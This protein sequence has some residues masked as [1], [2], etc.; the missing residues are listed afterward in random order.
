LVAFF[1]KIRLVCF[2]KLKF[3]ATVMSSLKDL[4]ALGKEFGYEGES[5]RKFIQEEQ[6]RERDERA[7]ARELEREL[8]REKRELEKKAKL[9]IIE[10]EEKKIEM[11][12]QLDRERKELERE[13]RELEREAE[14]RR[15]ELEK[16]AK[17]EIIEAEE[18]KIEMAK[19]LDREKRELEREV[20]EKRVELEKRARLEIIEAE[21]R[22]RQ[23]DHERQLELATA[24]KGE[25]VSA[26]SKL[27]G[28]KLPP[29]DDEKDNM[30]SYL[31]R[32]ERYAETQKWSRDDWALHLSALLKGKALDVCSRLPETMCLITTS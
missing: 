31:H 12:K 20:E 16:K 10:A 23:R 18:K 32:F 15:V 11:A 4:V 6:A 30:D 26:S 17:L 22:I 13:K 2:A 24:R 27:T 1:R 9:E 14:E 21:E 28:P 25:H 3:V 7:K 19:Q 29:F 5:L 8:E